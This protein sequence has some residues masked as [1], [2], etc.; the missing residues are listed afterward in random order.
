MLTLMTRCS[1]WTLLVL[2]VYMCGSPLR[3]QT[4]LKQV[5]RQGSFV[6]KMHGLHWTE[7]DYFDSREDEIALQH[8][9]ARYH[10]YGSKH[11]QAISK[12]Y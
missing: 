8:A 3:L 12:E 5:L 1:P 4:E 2:Y 9:I 7:P 11:F 10:A 6:Q